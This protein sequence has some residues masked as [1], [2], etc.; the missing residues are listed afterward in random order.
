[1]I[2][3]N[4][5]K[6]RAVEDDGKR[7]IVTTSNVKPVA[8][9]HF[10]REFPGVNRRETRKVAPGVSFTT[11][12][13]DDRKRDNARMA[14]AEAARVAPVAPPVPTPVLAPAKAKPAKKAAPKK[15]KGKTA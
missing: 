7:R 4:T 3:T 13:L 10:P 1:M 15:R 9:R 8:P 5:V 2:T 6:S 11:S 14:K 12:S